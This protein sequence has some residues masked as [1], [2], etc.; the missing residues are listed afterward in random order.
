MNS[1]SESFKCSCFNIPCLMAVSI[2]INLNFTMVLLTFLRPF[3]HEELIIWPVAVIMGN[4]FYSMGVQ[5]KKRRLQI[6]GKAM[7]LLNI[8]ALIL[9]NSTICLFA[10]SKFK[11]MVTKVL[12]K[13]SYHKQVSMITAVLVFNLSAVLALFYVYIY[14]MMVEKEKPVET[15]L[16]RSR[17]TRDLLMYQALPGDSLKEILVRNSENSVKSLASW[18]VPSTELCGMAK[19]S[20]WL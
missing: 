8:F 15:V 20:E 17:W 12:L 6:V 7:I 14:V 1:A 19:N 9:L 18:S 16:P 2:F 3:L 10:M 4:I 11:A 13:E 5:F